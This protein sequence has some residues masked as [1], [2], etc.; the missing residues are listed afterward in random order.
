MPPSLPA[1]RCLVSLVTPM[2]SLITI[3]SAA[4]R[5][6][7]AR[8]SP[9][10]GA[11]TPAG[12]HYGAGRH[13]DSSGATRRRRPGRCLPSSKVRRTHQPTRAGQRDT[14]RRDVSPGTLLLSQSERTLNRDS[15]Q[16]G[17]P[18]GSVGAFASL[19]KRQRESAGLRLDGAARGT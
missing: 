17:R 6:F 9:P 3:C 8:L 4:F 1:D 10:T 19:Q 7:L 12:H 14:G 11:H 18:G 15:A 5:A 2:L 16:I 13:R